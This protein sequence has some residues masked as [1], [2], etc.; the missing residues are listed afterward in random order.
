[1]VNEEANDNHFEVIRIIKDEARFPTKDDCQACFHP[2]LYHTLVAVI[3]KFFPYK[4]YAFQIRM[5]Q[6]V[7]CVAGI[8]TIYIVY[9]FLINKPLDDKLRLICFSMVALNPKLIGINAQATNDSFVILF[10]TLTLYFLYLFFVEKR[11]RDFFCMTIF[12][13]LGAISKPNGLFLFPGTLLVFLFKIIKRKVF[14]LSFNKSYLLHL[15]I[16]SIAF[17]VIVPFLGQYLYDYYKYGSPFI[18]NMAKA[19]L[20]NFLKE[21]Y[22]YR[23]GITSIVNS[24]FTFR[25]FDLIKHPTITNDKDNYP[26]HRTSLWSQLYG[27]ANFVHFDFW[28]PSWQTENKIVLSIGRAIFLFALLPT[29][30]LLLGIIKEIV[31]LFIFVAKRKFDFILNTN[32]WIFDIFFYISVLGIIIYTMQYRDFGCMKA[33]FIFPALLPFLNLFSLGCSYIYNMCGRKV[34][35]LL[36]LVFCILFILYFLDTVSL[37]H[38][39]YSIK[40]IF[41]L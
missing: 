11:M 22:V 17:L 10:S 1:M 36:D 25:F 5:A 9:L 12:A 31:S 6:I 23:P 37:I 40:P 28:P 18:I 13:I 33:I 7:N 26:L 39:L 32:D 20:P 15:L 35:F 34:I 3:L 8:L 24:Y 41:K 21:T 14:S 4:S 30:F 29:L 2:K 19:P 16:F 38:Q 27:R